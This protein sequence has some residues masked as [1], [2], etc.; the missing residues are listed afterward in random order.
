LVGVGTG[1]GG[2]GVLDGVGCGTGVAVGVLTGALQEE[3]SRMTNKR[4]GRIFNIHLSASC[5][6]GIVESF[7]PQS[8]AMFLAPIWIKPHSLLQPTCFPY[9]TAFIRYSVI[10]TDQ[11]RFYVFFFKA[12][13]SVSS[14]LK[15]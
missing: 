5:L 10:A 3:S 14:C 11:H 12:V 4:K 8:H 6:I 2:G 7:Y 1:D 15:G 13:K 9:A